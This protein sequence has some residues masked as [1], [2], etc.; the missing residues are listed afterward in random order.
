MSRCDIKAN[1]AICFAAIAGLAI[2]LCVGLA[3][4]RSAVAQ[5]WSLGEEDW[6]PFVPWRADI[7]GRWRVHMPSREYCIMDFSGAPETGH[8]TVAAMGFCPPEFLSR[9]RWR[10]EGDH[11]VIINRRGDLLADLAL[12]GRGYLKGPIASGAYVSLI[13]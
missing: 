7:A 9:P 10:R 12:V 4:T 13:R 8:G 11:V 5:G 2:A 3:G 6:R 1:C